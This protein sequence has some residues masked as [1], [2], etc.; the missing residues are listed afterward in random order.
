[1]MKNIFTV[2]NC[3]E[4][5]IGQSGDITSNDESSTYHVPA[6][7]TC[8][9]LTTCCCTWHEI[10]AAIIYKYYKSKSTHSRCGLNLR[11]QMPE[12]KSAMIRGATNFLDFVYDVAKKEGTAV[13]WGTPCAD[14]GQNVA[15]K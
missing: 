1:M 12:G 6:L 15:V 10:M 13:T 7:Y 9:G 4:L 2:G 11:D 8:A 3:S 5:C 14:R